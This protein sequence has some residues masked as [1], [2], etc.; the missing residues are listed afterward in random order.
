M[1]KLVESLKKMLD[2]YSIKQV[3]LAKSLEVRPQFINSV[4]KGRKKLNFKQ[5]EIIGEKL[6]FKKEDILELKK[7]ASNLYDDEEMMNWLEM[8]VENSMKYEELSSDEKMQKIIENICKI[9]DEKTREEILDF[10]L[11]KLQKNNK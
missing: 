11:Y 10:I 5:I 2:K 7:N 1:N 8:I 4:F 6:N 3:D 9:K